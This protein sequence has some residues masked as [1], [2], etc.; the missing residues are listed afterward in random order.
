MRTYVSI[1]LGVEDVTQKKMTENVSSKSILL[2]ESGFSAQELQQFIWNEK[3]KEK[4]SCKM[5]S[6]CPWG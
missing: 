4:F 2:S 5:V 6:C 1:Y 3:E